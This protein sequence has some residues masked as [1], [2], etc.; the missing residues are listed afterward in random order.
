[1]NSL[2][3]KH[4]VFRFGE[5]DKDLYDP[6]S[7]VQQGKLLIRY[8]AINSANLL[9]MPYFQIFKISFREFILNV[10]FDF[11]PLCKSFE[12]DRNKSYLSN[13]AS[14]QLRL[15]KSIMLPTSVTSLPL[16]LFKIVLFFD[17]YVIIGFTL[18]NKTL[19][20]L[21]FAVQWV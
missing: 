4:S 7:R 3:E 16:G 17:L 15:L 2:L 6:K 19:D 5:C 21:L 11:L 1:M 12:S 9:R 13:F 20:F 14:S 8:P 10:R 18:Q